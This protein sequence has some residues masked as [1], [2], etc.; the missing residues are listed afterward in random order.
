MLELTAEHNEENEMDEIFSR[1][2]TVKETL[3]H[4]KAGSAVVVIHTPGGYTD[5][6]NM[7]KN[8]AYLERIRGD[9][10]M[11]Q[12][13][14]RSRL[15]EMLVAESKAELGCSDDDKDWIEPFPIGT[16]KSD[17]RRTAT[18]TDDGK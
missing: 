7:L 17:H 1:Y 12:R 13:E 3:K 11:Q 5:M 9:L 15:I 10:M 6:D 4:I 16:P 18:D 14:L 8:P 2:Q